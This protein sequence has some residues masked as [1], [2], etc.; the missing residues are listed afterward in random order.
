MDMEI[1]TRFL[2][3]WE[4][5]FPNNELPLVC[6]YSDDLNSADFPDAPK[7]NKRGLTCIFSQLAPVRAGKARAFNQENFGCWGAKG[8]LG[9]IPSKAD[10]PTIDFLVNVEKYKE[11]AEHVKAM[12]T[13][14]PPVTAPK[15]YLVFKRWDL[16]TENDDPQVV[17]FFCKADVLSGLHGLANYDTMDPHGVIAPFGSGCESIVSYAMKDLKSDTPKAVIGLFD[18]STRTCVKPDLLSFSAP[19]PKFMSMLD[20]MDDCFLNTFIWENVRKRF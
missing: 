7:P 20:H 2:E 19:W 1:K 14:N 17:I 13:S 10:E 18:P 11:G 12:F 4:K 16:L 9:F 8:V 15:K 3:K 5:Y 6:Y